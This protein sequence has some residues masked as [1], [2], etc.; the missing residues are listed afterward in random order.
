MKEDGFSEGTYVL[1]G[2]PLKIDRREF[3]KVAGGGI[4]VLF[5]IGDTST[6]PGQGPQSEYP[7]DFNAYLLIGE[8]GKVQCFTGKIEMGQGV[9][10]SLAQ[11]AA[12]ELDVSLDTIE[13]VMGDTALCPWDRGTFGSRTTRFFGPALRAAAAEARAVLVE[14]ASERLK[15][16]KDRLAVEN[17]LV[18]E[19]D[20]K[21][22]RVTYAQ[23]ARGRKITRKIEGTAAEK[24]V[25][26]FKVIGIPTPRIDALEKVAGKAKYA[27]DIRYPGMLYARILRPPAHRAQ[28]K[29]LDTSAAEKM[30]GVLVVREEDLTAVLHEDP[31]MAAQSLDA[32]KADFDIP[33]ERVDDKN[34]FEHLLQSAPEGQGSEERGSLAEG[35][36]LSAR[37]FE[38][39][40]LNSYVAHAPV[41]T[42][43]A[44]ASYRDGKIE[45]W[46]S[47]QSP[48]GDQRRVAEA[49]GIPEEN[50]RVRA[51]FVGGGFGGKTSN[52]Q[53]V[54]AA[55]L[56]RLTG[57]PVQVARTR[58][59]EF[60]LDTFRPAAV[61][62]IKSG[63]DRQGRMSLWDYKVYFAGSRGS[64]Q[65]YDVPHNL[66]TTYG[67]SWGGLP[68]AHPF[69]TGAWRA[70][71]ANTNVFARESHIDL[72]ASRAGID[73][74]EFRLANLKDE[75]MIR[76][77]EAVAEKSGWARSPAPSGRGVGISCGIDSGTYVAAV[78]EVEVDRQSGRILVKRVVCAQD[79][80]LVINPLGAKVQMEGCITMG[81][82]YALTEEIH[83]RGGQISDLNFGTYEIPRFSWVPQIETV[84]IDAKDFPVQGGGEPA[85]INMGAVTANALHDATGA[86]LWQL[87]MTPERVREALKG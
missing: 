65:F 54:E 36:K 57:R 30:K 60:F 42:H 78:A 40:Y 55:R 27:G 52:P 62:K 87:P 74:L 6:L 80:G 10:T 43:T 37:I 28:L 82:G 14:L 7:T 38:E 25:S 32:V 44:A 26:E 83:F 20:R 70:P 29:S 86:R 67:A 18:F 61:V 48:F 79:M 17:G 71:G 56:S 4:L 45:L 69:A 49:L 35:E 66:I 59:E 64:D 39:T 63:I 11:E 24:A 84:L 1:P 19:R 21:D 73:P 16:P 22:N 23:L 51:P 58:E 77:L 3:F 8:D 81:L 5:T 72:M 33:E 68:G 46:V 9:I 15:T 31:G 85:I 12:D 53:A 34:I 76:V 75:R 41:E 50:V 13:M 2:P 47:T